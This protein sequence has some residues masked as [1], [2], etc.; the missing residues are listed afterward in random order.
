MTDKA[1]LEFVAKL[2]D[3]ASKAATVL[4]GN[5]DELGGPLKPMTGEVDIDVD[6]AWFRE[7][8]AL[9]EKAF[10]EVEEDAKEAGE[11]SGSAFGAGLKGALAG[12]AIAAVG[13]AAGAMLAASFASALQQEN[14]LSKLSASLG[15]SPQES[16]RIGGVAGALYADAY[17][18]SLADVT[19]A[20]EAVV[21]SIDGIRDASDEA[22]TAASEDALNFASAFEVDTAR[23]VQIVGQM[24]RTGLVA[25]AEEGF[26][27]L[28]AGAQGVPKAIREDLLDAVDEYGPF[29]AALGYSG[30]EAF[31]LLTDASEK[32]MYGIDK[33]GDALKEFG[34]LATDVSSKDVVGLYEAL[35]FGAQDMADKLLAGG[36]SAKE[37]TGQIIDGILGITD[38]AQ[39]ASAAITLFGT[40]L[41]DLGVN[42]IPTF[43]ASLKG[44]E[45]GLGDFSQAS[46]ELSDTLNDDA[47]VALTEQ[48]RMLQQMGTDALAT[49]MPYLIDF[50]TWAKETPGFLTALTVGLGLAA[51]AWAAV[52]LAASPW[53]AIALG[54]AAGIALIVFVIKNWGP[55][56]DWIGQ[57]VAAVGDWI[58]GVFDK[59][60]TWISDRVRAIIT[61]VKANWPLLLA[62]LT[63]PIGLAVLWIS[64]HMDQIRATVSDRITAVIRFFR[65]LPG[66]ILSA[67]GNLAGTLVGTG[68]DLVEGIW[69]GIKGAGRWL[70]DKLSGWAS[71]VIPG[72]IK[73][74][75]GIASPS[76]VG[77]WIGQMF[78]LGVGGG[79][80][81]EADYVAGAAE[82]LAESVLAPMNDLSA[83]IDRFAA[84][85]VS[86]AGRSDVATVVEIRHVVTSPDGS[87][88]TMTAEELAVLLTDPVAAAAT[89]KAVRS[90][91]ARRDSRTLAATTV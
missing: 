22:L 29:F 58:A 79:V 70:M 60:R 81:D 39:R 91:V 90:T 32:G 11:E 34:I 83:G 56:M 5:L 43:L 45:D 41:E 59:V 53:L 26:D 1:T 87:V 37:A 89:E 47:S 3:E 77:T 55:I 17:G 20:V 35:G 13:T 76:K 42:E 82:Q 14:D 2:D 23:S 51:I 67:V 54:V 73:K 10:D 78:G 25:D 86:V 6:E 15:L 9:S 80:E 49:L 52:T 66:K 44:G 71:S 85:T 69:S 64:R 74:A 46:E 12:G 8:D 28:I 61:W 50:L 57:K 36:D 31:K 33:T 63:G 19:G 75:L 72:P 65:E 21:S 62:I 38:P 27:L 30:E 24:I 40:P 48:T 88:T 18:E 84:P 16:E 7:L 4:K 68:R